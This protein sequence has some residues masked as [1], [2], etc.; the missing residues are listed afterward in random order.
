GI[1]AD[2][3]IVADRCRVPQRLVAP[4][5]PA[6]GVGVVDEHDAVGN[7]DIVADGDKF[8]DEAVRLDAAVAANHDAFLDFNKR[9]NEAVVADDA[10][11]KVHGLDDGDI[12]PERYIDDT[13]FLER[14]LVHDHDQGFATARKVSHTL[15][16]SSSVRSAHMGRLKTRS[17]ARSVS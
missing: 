3:D 7:G 10:A 17:A 4:G 6:G 9:A 8:A 11:V 12:P 15:A 13:D 2:G 14:G 1:A 5:R 16:A